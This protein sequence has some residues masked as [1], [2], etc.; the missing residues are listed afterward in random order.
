MQL[1]AFALTVAGRRSNNEDAVCIRP[2]LGLFVVADGLGGYDGGEIASELAVDTILELV[3]RGAGDGDV[4]WPYKLDPQHSLAE[5]EILVAT[6]LAGDRIAAQRIGVLGQMGS[7]VAVLKVANGN[8]IIAHVGDSRIYRLRGSELAQLTIDHS[9]VTQMIAAGMQPDAAFPW[10]HV[11]TRA[12]GMPNPEPDI[13]TASVCP[14]DVFL[15]CS[16]G[17][18]EPLEPA[19]LAKLLAAPPALACQQL[20]DAAYEAGSRDNI[21]AVVVRC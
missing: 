3:R 5:N 9:L 21:S 11:I 7:T 15:L 18:Y 17:L 6:R 1:D 16:D 19:V 2:D 12:L 4:T 14:G 20:V 13:Q 10:R 8:A